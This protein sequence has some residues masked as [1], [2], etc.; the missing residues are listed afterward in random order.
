VPTNDADAK[1]K[2]YQGQRIKE[3]YKDQVQKLN[4]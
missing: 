4:Q 1:K 2:K 3:Q